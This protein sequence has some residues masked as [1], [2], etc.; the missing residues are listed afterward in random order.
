[1][2]LT[3]IVV[4]GIIIASF[5]IAVYL[6]PQMP[7]QM[8]SHWNARDEVDGFM[9]KFWGLFMMPLVLLGMYLLFIGIPRIDPLKQNIQKFMK[10]YEGFIVLIIAFMFYVYLLTIFWSLGFRFSM[11]QMMVPALGGLFYYMGI[12]T[13]NAKRNWFIGIR[14]PW[15]LSSDSVWDKTHKIGGKLFKLSGIIAVI[16]ILFGDYA[17]WFVIG[18]VL[19]VAVY[20]IAFSYVEYQKVKR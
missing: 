10:F 17:I 3:R 8:A 12:L 18:P 9:P 1:M 13:E 2:K 14:T 20:T 15:T 4:W 19:A 16:G 7:E 6:Y 5:V 11:L